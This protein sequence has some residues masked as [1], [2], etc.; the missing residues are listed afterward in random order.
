MGTLINEK[1]IKLDMEVTTKEEAIEN[2][3]KLIHEEKN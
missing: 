3:A 2:L 1:L